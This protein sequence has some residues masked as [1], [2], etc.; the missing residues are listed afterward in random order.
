[1]RLLH[2]EEER[3][4]HAMLAVHMEAAKSVKLLHHMSVYLYNIFQHQVL[5]PGQTHQQP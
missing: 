3:A 5:F 1:M 4:Y 2:G